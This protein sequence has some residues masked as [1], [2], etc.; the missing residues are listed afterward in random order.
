MLEFNLDSI[1]IVFPDLPIILNG[2]PSG[3]SSGEAKYI[4]Y[5]PPDECSESIQS[6]CAY[7][8]QYLVPISLQVAHQGQLIRQSLVVKANLGSVGDPNLVL[9]TVFGATAL[10][11]FGIVKAVRT[12]GNK[13]RTHYKNHKSKPRNHL[14]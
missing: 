13:K 3:S 6:N 1:K 9:F 14:K 10:V 5:I 7:Q 8:K 11:G 4:I 12:N 2:D